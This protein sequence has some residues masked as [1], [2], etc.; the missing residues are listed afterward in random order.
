MNPQEILLELTI[1]S[2]ENG[3]VMPRGLIERT[4]FF[5]DK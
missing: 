2:R 4:T 1:R 3:S 5:D